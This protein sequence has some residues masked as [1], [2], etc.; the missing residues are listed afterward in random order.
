MNINIKRAGTFLCCCYM[1]L[2]FFLIIGFCFKI[3]YEKTTRSKILPFN[4]GKKNIPECYHNRTTLFLGVLCVKA[5]FSEYGVF[6]FL[7]KIIA[8]NIKVSLNMENKSDISIP[9]YVNLL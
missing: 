7:K 5:A 8:L 6:F 4:W 1:Y 9:E 3:D 2:R